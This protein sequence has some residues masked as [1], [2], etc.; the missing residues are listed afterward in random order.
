M[1]AQKA[2]VAVILFL[3]RTLVVI[4]VILG[5]IRLGEYAYAYGYSIVSNA[6]MEPEPGRDIG[7]V[8][9]DD[10]DTKEVAALLK[11]RGLIEDETIFRI[12][13]IINKHEEDLKPGNYVLNTSMTPKEMMQVLSGEAQE[14]EEEE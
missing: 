1:N 4:L 3:F 8:L 13:L 9:T 12:Q 5:I 7:I 11:R 10:M 14:E 2:I 6:A